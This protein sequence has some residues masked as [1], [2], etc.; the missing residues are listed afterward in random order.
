MRYLV[1]G[2]EDGFV[3]VDIDTGFAHGAVKDEGR[4]LARCGGE[5]TAVPSDSS[6]GK[7]AGASGLVGRLG[8]EILYDGYGLEIVLPVKRA[9][10][11]PVVGDADSGPAGIGIRD[12]I[13]PFGF[14]LVELPSFLK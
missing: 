13:C 5:G 8:F 1:V 14:T 4:L 10:Y 7:S 9:E 11:C 3:F 2:P 12:G 6:V